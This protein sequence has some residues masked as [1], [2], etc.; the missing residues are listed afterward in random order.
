MTMSVVL[1]SPPVLS[2]Y[3]AGA[4]GVSPVAPITFISLGALVISVAFAL[5]VRALLHFLIRRESSQ[6]EQVTDQ[7]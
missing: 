7:A 2:L 4:L 1:I 3:D 6:G 5:G